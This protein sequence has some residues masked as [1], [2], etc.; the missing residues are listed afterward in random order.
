MSLEASERKR[1]LAAASPWLA[2]ILNG[3]PGLGTG[4][5][6]QR[7]WRAYGATTVLAALWIG[8]ST[9][10]P[11]LLPGDG[12]PADLTI[13]GLLGLAALTALEAFLAGRRARM[14]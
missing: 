3:V 4:Y 13:P 5:I 14:N 2:A 8:L 1:I 11:P 10:L 7:R 12:E 6:Y 9:S